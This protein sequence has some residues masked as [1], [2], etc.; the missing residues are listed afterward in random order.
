MASPFI[1]GILSKSNPESFEGQ[2]GTISAKIIDSQKSEAADL[3]VDAA[4]SY[5]GFGAD[6]SACIL[7]FFKKITLQLFQ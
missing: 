7:L 5:S 2:D 4:A 3:A 1:P 6:V